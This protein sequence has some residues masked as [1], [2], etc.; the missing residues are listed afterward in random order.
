VDGNHLEVVQFLL[1][2]GAKL[3]EHK[4]AMLE[5]A[6]TPEMRAVLEAAE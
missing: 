2:S 6:K 5:A 3:G 1:A 4:A